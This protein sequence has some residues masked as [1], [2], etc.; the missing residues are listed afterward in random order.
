MLDLTESDIYCPY[1]GEI[2]TVL[3]N[4]ED[5]GQPYIEDCQVCCRPIE[6]MVTEGAG[7]ELVVSVATDTE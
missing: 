7:G 6:F 5:V 1:C 3:L 4:P 2:I